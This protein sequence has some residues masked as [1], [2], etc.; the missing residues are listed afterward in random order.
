MGVYVYKDTQSW[1][2]LTTAK[3][4]GPSKREMMSSYDQEALVLGTS[5]S[6]WEGNTAAIA[7][8]GLGK[9]KG[10][11]RGEL[12]LEAGNPDPPPPPQED[13]EKEAQG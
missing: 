6:F 12:A 7:L 10:K 8:K 4:D 11:R 9:G 5:A 1:T 3:T 2:R 13:P